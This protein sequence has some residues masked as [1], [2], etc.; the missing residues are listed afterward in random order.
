MTSRR[1][2]AVLALVGAGIASSSPIKVPRGPAPVIDGRIDSIEWQGS[3]V[4]QLTNGLTIRLRHDGQHL[5]LGVSSTE[6]GF[7]S[8]CALQG[9]TI[10]VLHASAALG[11]VAYRK[12]GE[13]WSSRDTAFVYAMRN[14]ALT[15]Q[16]REERRA[17]LARNR[18]LAS[19]ARMGNSRQH[20]IQVSLG[21]LD[22]GPRVALGYFRM[23]GAPVTWP[24]TLAGAGEGC[25]ALKLL[26][27][28]ALENP[29]FQPRMY[30][31]LE[32]AQ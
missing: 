27:G 15:D 9:D 1:F 20:E 22:P 14:T 4:E 23:Q 25:G 6:E 11:A 7:P 32:L 16:A 2:A 10:R 24:T 17:Y 8:V 29:T 18:W 5:F 21:L 31:E 19:T 3:A 13:S 12:S 26:Q 30:L 28:Y